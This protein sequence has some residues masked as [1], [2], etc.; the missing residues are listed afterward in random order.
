MRAALSSLLLLAL[1]S[2]ANLVGKFDQNSYAAATDLKAESVALM[3]HGAEPAAGHRRQITDL[4]SALSAQL[5]YEEGKGKQ[6]RFSSAQWKLLVAPDG[7][8]LGTFLKNWTD[9]YSPDYVAKKQ[10]QVER[11]FDEILRAEGYKNE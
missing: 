8:M 5:A 4:Q 10:I 2:C 1:V 9:G 3:V 11:A 6:N 7:D